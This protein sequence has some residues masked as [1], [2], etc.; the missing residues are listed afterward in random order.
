MCSL[1]PRNW[2]VELGWRHWEGSAG[3]C[4]CASPFL[5]QRMA[6]QGKSIRDNSRCWKTKHECRK[7]KCASDY[8]NKDK[9]RRKNK[10]KRHLSGVQQCLETSATIRA[11]LCCAG[12]EGLAK[13]WARGT[14]TTNQSNMSVCISQL[15]LRNS[16]RWSN[17][18]KDWCQVCPGLCAPLKAVPGWEKK[19]LARA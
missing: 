14:H 10:E 6:Q 12:C 5:I 9:L 3:F 4:V 15:M 11:T 2:E 8:L 17:L 16:K 19:A 1:W 18:S 7:C 13:D